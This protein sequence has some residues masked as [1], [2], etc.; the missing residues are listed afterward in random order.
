MK[1]SNSI[2][3]K[4]TILVIGIVLAVPALFY[5]TTAQ[6]FHVWMVNETF[7][8]GLLIFPISCWL[9]WRQRNVLLQCTIK[10]D[11]RVLVLVVP[12]LFFWFLAN[13]IDVQ[14]AKQLAMISLVPIMLWLLLGSTILRS[15][16]FPVCYLFFAIPLGQALIP[17]LMDF[18]ANFTVLLVQLTGVPIYQDGLFFVLPSGSWSVVEECSGVRYLIASL[19]LGAV[20]AH[21]NYQSI[22]KR[23]VYIAA[24]IVV[25]IAANGLRAYGIV[26]IGHLSDMQLATGVDHLLYGWVFFGII[27]FL[28]IYIGSFWSDSQ[29]NHAKS[30]GSLT[31][32]LPVERKKVLIS[33]VFI[34]I[35]AIVLSTSLAYREI[36]PVTGTAD[37][38]TL[39][40]QS[41]D[42]WQRQPGVD[43]G[44]AP[45]RL[46]PDINIERVYRYDDDLVQLNIAHYFYQR[47]G[48][49]AVSS[50]NRLTNPYG[51]D[52][53][54]THS[55]NLKVGEHQIAE[56]EIQNR[57]TKI[58]VWQWYLIGDKQTSNPYVA[59]LYEAY[60]MILENRQ[61]GSSVT[62]ATRL[63]NLEESRDRLEFFYNESVSDIR[64]ALSHLSG[65]PEP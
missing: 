42:S 63:D 23:I 5:R 37:A 49:E 26:M 44:W 3:Y 16:L 64:A 58:L 43:I 12:V 24:A 21:M 48:A 8:H 22:R 34:C 20:F 55:G 57:G 35:A 9:I 38:T 56:G 30:S 52:W 4:I 50:E 41:F 60:N 45:E 46:T 19:A 29:L 53:K 6:M 28:M 36:Q 27:I 18:T 7:T 61:D 1:L 59:K 40:P 14:V 13:A 32:T 17:P 33:L 2:N 25:P 31:S 62:I 39:L 11:P 10:P 15:V 54:L 51:G 65:Q 47:A